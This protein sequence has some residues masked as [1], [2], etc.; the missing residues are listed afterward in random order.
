MALGVEY[1]S[2][3]INR[4]SATK[5]SLENEKADLNDTAVNIIYIYIY[6][7]IL[8]Q[9]RIY[10]HFD[11][12]L[13]IVGSLAARNTEFTATIHAPETREGRTEL[14][15]GYCALVIQ[16][17]TSLDEAHATYTISHHGATVGSGLKDHI[18]A[19]RWL[20]LFDSWRQ[21]LRCCCQVTKADAQGS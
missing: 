3:S 4:H 1:W 6:I 9:Q 21:I 11:V 8:Q 13:C 18:C 2:R 14:C 17:W 10:I 16:F 19:L 7:Y 20:W 12:L 15:E 5:F